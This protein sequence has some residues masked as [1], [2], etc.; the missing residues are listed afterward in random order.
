MGDKI[1]EFIY[2]HDNN[3]LMNF[4]EKEVKKL[5]EVLNKYQLSYRDF[6][7]LKNN[8][9]F[10]LEIE[11]KVNNY[12]KYQNIKLNKKWILVK[13][14]F[15]NGLEVVSPVLSDVSKSWKGLSDVCNIL[16]K[17][18]KVTKDCGGHIHI[19][20]Q[21]LG[22]SVKSWLNFVKIWSIYESV[23]YKFSAGE[24]YSSRPDISLYANQCR[25]SF[26]E[27]YDYSVNYMVDNV[28]DIINKT[29]CL[30]KGLA[31]NFAN[32][33]NID[34]FEYDN[35]IEIRCPNGSLNEVVWQNNVNF[36]V[37]LLKLCKY[38]VIDDEYINHLYLKKKSK[39]YSYLYYNYTNLDLAV[40][41]VDLVFDNNLDKVYFLRQYLRDFNDTYINDLK[42]L[43]KSK[44]FTM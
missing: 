18:G 2:P 33:A 19:G 35:T 30:I 36:F 26:I 28:N 22:N 20:T 38:G 1:F 43:Q 5:V 13:E 31:I 24:F 42:G 41:L 34:N 21:V 44:K 8:S 12:K 17:M 3:L 4:D 25:D 39:K 10:G 40:D 27:T 23:I 37:K 9:S 32:V 15:K 7:F 11:F 14:Q 16:D 6:L 29:D